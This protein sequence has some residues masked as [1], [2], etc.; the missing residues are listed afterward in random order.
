MGR[1]SLFARDALKKFRA[2]ETMRQDS[3]PN[4]ANMTVQDAMDLLKCR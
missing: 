4:E 2:A 3:L 1:G